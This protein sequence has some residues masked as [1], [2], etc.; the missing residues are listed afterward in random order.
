[1]GHGKA[2]GSCNGCSLAATNLLNEPKLSSPHKEDRA[3]TNIP[4]MQ[5]IVAQPPTEGP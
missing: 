1:M 2:M 5:R 4:P 3:P